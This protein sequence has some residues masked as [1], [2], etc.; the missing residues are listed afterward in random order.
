VN[1]VEIA[2]V[3]EEELKKGAAKLG[4]PQPTRHFKRSD[5]FQP[6]HMGT[7]PGAAMRV[8]R[9][10]TLTTTSPAAE[11]PSAHQSVW[12]PTATPRWR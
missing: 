5:T 9:S 8:L 10:G 6:T 12:A 4:G 7:T 11:I 1:I 3:V 2:G